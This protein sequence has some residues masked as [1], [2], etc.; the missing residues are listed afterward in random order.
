MRVSS[1]TASLDSRQAFPRS[2]H[3]SGASQLTLWSRIKHYFHKLDR[4]MTAI[5]YA[6]A[7]NLDAVQKML[8][9]NKGMNRQNRPAGNGRMECQ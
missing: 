7:G 4:L 2:E 1:A 9:E 8:D 5:A 6:E 3:E